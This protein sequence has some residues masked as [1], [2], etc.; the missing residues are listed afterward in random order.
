MQDQIEN[1]SK[2]LQEKEELYEKKI[3]LIKKEMM[4]EITLLKQ[5]NCLDEIEERHLS[6]IK[7]L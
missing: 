6:E 3:S 2:A 1:F 4:E 7:K 5:S